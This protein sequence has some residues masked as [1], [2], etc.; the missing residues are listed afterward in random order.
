MT[1]GDP[2]RDA[3]NEEGDGRLDPSREVGAVVAAGHCGQRQQHQGVPGGERMGQHGG[4]VER[5]GSDQPAGPGLARSFVA[6]KIAQCG[7][8]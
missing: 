4:G 7:Q 3:R 5:K 8:A 1:T 2:Q 6:G